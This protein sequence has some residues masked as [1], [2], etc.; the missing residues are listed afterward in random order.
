MFS[1]VILGSFLLFAANLGTFAADGDL[2]PLFTP[3]V[4]WRGA[5]VTD[6][7]FQPDGKIVVVGNFT[8]VNGRNYNCVARYNGDGTL[9]T[10]FNIGP[11]A[12]NGSNTVACNG[13][14]NAVA[15]QIVG[16]A[17]KILIGGDFTQ[18]GTLPGGGVRGRLARLNED[19][20][21]DPTFLGGAVGPSGI[22]D[23]IV[24]QP[25]D[26][27]IL[28][29]SF[30]TIQYNGVPVGL[31][32]RVNGGDGSLDT[33]FNTNLGA[34][35]DNSTT[36]IAIQPLDGK[37]LVAGSF[38]SVKGTPANGIARLNTDGMVDITFSMNT[39]T[40][41]NGVVYDIAVQ[42]ADNK[43]LIAGAFFSFNGTL[44]D[45]IARLNLSGTHDL[46]FVPPAV[47]GVV[48]ALSIDAGGKIYA[49]GNSTIVRLNQATGSLD[50]GFDLGAGT[51]GGVTKLAI[52]SSSGLLIA[53]GGFTHIHGTVKLA[54]ARILPSGIPNADFEPVIGNPGV[55]N[56]VV[57]QPDNKILVG[58][59]FYGANDGIRH[60]ITR[61]NPDG[62][63]DGS[64]FPGL[65]DND[66]DGE[67]KA[68]ALQPDG[69]ILVGGTFNN[70]G[71]TNRGLVRLNADGSLDPTFTCDTFG[72]YSIA[73][74][75]NG[76]IVIGGQ[77]VNVNG[78]TQ[79]RVARLNSDG[80]LDP[81][82]TATGVFGCN[83]GVEKVVLQPDGKILVGGYFDR[84]NGVTGINNFAR[85][86]SL[87]GSID[88]AFTA[89]GG[90]GFDSAVYD[91]DIQ[92]A[93]NKILVT[94]GFSNFNATS[95]TG[96]ARL[97][98]G[99]ALDGTFTTGAG[100]NN[101]GAV[102]TILTPHGIVVIGG[103]ITYQGVN[104]PGI[105]RMTS[106]GL[107]D[108]TFNPGDGLPGSTLNTVAMQSSG[109]IIIG[110]GFTTYGA[111]NG[112]AR[113]GL[114][115]LEGSTSVVTL[116]APF[117]FDGDGKTDISMF[118]PATTE[119]W[120]EKSSDGLVPIITFGLATDKL[121]PADYTGDGKTDIAIWR[122]AEQNWWILRSEN[123][124]D[125]TVHFGSPG[126]VLVP[127]DYDGDGKAD[128]AIFREFP[129]GGGGPQ[130]WIQKSLTGLQV[131]SF[132]LPGDKP[133]PADYDGDGKVDIAV[134]RPM[135]G[136][137]GL[138][139]WWLKRST[140]GDITLT[141][142]LG[143]ATDKPVQGDYT[144]DGKADV[145]F[146]RETTGEWFVYR[147]EDSFSSSSYF[148]FP[149][150]KMGDIPTPGDYDGDGQFDAAVYRPLGNHWF[151]NRTAT[152]VLWF[153][154][155]GLAGDYPVPNSY[156]P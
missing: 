45:R 135:P 22:I 155:F 76:K 66:F 139:E 32:M 99:G 33:T 73:V 34:G 83:C 55:V 49:G 47:Q 63:T 71:G 31:F 117:D 91:I 104:R 156:V 119:W 13:G 90:M 39:G 43:I 92:P 41:A 95:R 19:G 74:Q 8:V 93:D 25:S 123:S 97:E 37:I 103:F 112:P 56:V 23:D 152:N 129:P 68:I 125:F 134:F 102:Q 136:G 26:N 65:G 116:P 38:T 143:L 78:V 154:P 6:F 153:H 1:L 46:M 132:G 62:T 138:P 107:I 131:E 77:F 60:R 146:W 144:R 101:L 75:P 94:G 141:P 137:G 2:D 59:N 57:V 118:R 133:V 7:A 58:G 84:I 121:V 111:A 151:L 27:K 88:M 29:A 72:V 122:P 79:S 54:L 115:R 69:K 140:A 4:N 148:S 36:R 64:F 82:F 130:W 105:V 9:D 80:S 86:N 30:N 147:S 10:S 52:Q 11:G 40:G 28:L 15:I 67:V 50:A 149:F 89:A 120:I 124:I 70:M 35:F 44:T 142:L 128:I 145:A 18:F 98:T 106:S 16:G 21:V 53:A 96:I 150:G 100:F 12:S 48:S 109:K 17:T 42:P 126:D 85:L 20:S 110:G 24:V 114:A 51:N 61:L 108:V 81:M 14:P 87:D 113:L 127:A 5:A 3:S